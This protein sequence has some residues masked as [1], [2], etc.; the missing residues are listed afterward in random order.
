M[1]LKEMVPEHVA[2]VKILLNACFGEDAWSPEMIRAELEK[3]E[4]RCT[5]A[6]EGEMTVGFLAFE[7]I[8]DE[9]SVIEIAVHP[10]YR[11]QGIAGHMITSALKDAEN[12]GA[13]F[14]EVRE[15]NTPAITLYESIGFEKIGIRKDYYD[16]PKEN[17]LIYRFVSE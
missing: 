13:V 10:D 6:V 9:G 7:L 1:I 12:A 8:A 17:G 14:L 5:V 11:R 16:K 4:S 2:D 3:P 15:S